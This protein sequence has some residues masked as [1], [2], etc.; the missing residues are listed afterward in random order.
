MYTTFFDI[1]AMPTDYDATFACWYIYFRFRLNENFASD[2][3][4]GDL[5][6]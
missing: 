1:K 3:A 4:E 5:E 2:I 6:R